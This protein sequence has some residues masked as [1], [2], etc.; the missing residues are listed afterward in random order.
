[1]AGISHILSRYRVSS[2]PLRSERKVEL[3]ALVLTFIL[4]FQLLYGVVSLYLSSQP[5]P[6]FPSPDSMQ[7]GTLQGAVLVTAQQS[8]EFRARP[9]FWPTRRPVSEGL[10]DEGKPKLAPT[11]KS[12]LNTVKLLGVIGSGN[13]AVV[14]V[15]VK[16]QKKRILLGDKVVGW[17]LQSVQQGQAVFTGDGQSQS[18]KLKHTDIN[19]GTYKNNDVVAE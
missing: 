7:I 17:T 2:D 19:I 18:L 10:N 3:A 9:V 13:S 16:G 14:I 15:L 6:I 8:N 11:K 12:A 1:M 4:M 5:S